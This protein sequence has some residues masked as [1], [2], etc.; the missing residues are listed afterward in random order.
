MHF[1]TDAEHA[2]LA[3]AVQ[4][5]RDA[6]YERPAFLLSRAW[7]EENE[8]AKKRRKRRATDEECEPTQGE[9]W[10]GAR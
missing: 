10:R 5:L 6:G 2:E 3:Q 4:M 9:P 1:M 8:R 7:R